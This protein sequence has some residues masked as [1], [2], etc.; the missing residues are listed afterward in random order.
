MLLEKQRKREAEEQ[1]RKER[2]AREAEQRKENIRK[3]L[4][5]CGCA[6]GIITAIS[7]WA[8]IPRP[9]K[10]LGTF[11]AE[12][13]SLE[14]YNHIGDYHLRLTNP[15]GFRLRKDRYVKIWGLDITD[16]SHQLLPVGTEVECRF[17]ERRVW[18]DDTSTEAKAFEALC[19]NDDVDVYG[20]I[21]GHPSVKRLRHVDDG[22]YDDTYITA[23]KVNQPASQYTFNT[24]VLPLIRQSN[25]PGIN[26]LL[27][28]QKPGSTTL[29]GGFKSELLDVAKINRA[30]KLMA[31]C[32]AGNVSGPECDPYVLRGID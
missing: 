29:P 26:P 6:A 28:P 31:D 17:F 24:D 25:K 16:N 10:T 8:N 14:G 23:W 13:M 7:L 20:R 2:L 4:I 18:R 21:A 11:K 5:F 3:A 12:V 27:L 19:E 9:P 30:Y 1:Q 15:G 32:Q 22:Y